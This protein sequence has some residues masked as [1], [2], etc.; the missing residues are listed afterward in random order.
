MAGQ[1]VKDSPSGFRQRLCRIAAGQKGPAVFDHT[2]LPIGFDRTPGQINDHVL[3]VLLKNLDFEPFLERIDGLPDSLLPFLSPDQRNEPI[4][5]LFKRDII[6]EF[7]QIIF[8]R[9]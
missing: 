9:S 8:R 5:R 4:F 1:R 3:E 7:I 6:I 2:A